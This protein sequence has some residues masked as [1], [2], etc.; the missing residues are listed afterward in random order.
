M[1]T[2]RIYYA[3]RMPHGARDW[4]RTYGL[5]RHGS[6]PDET[7][8]SEIEW[9]E[10]LEARNPPEALQAFFREHATDRTRVMWV[11]EMGQSNELH[12]LEDYDPDKTYIWIEDDKLMEYQ[13][14]AEATPGMATCPLCGGEG[15]VVAEVAEQFLAEEDKEEG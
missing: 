11:D 14:I 12:G 10:E 8:H 13:G 3:E 6:E 1:P 7:R 5:R 9:E 4:M 15:E 2:F